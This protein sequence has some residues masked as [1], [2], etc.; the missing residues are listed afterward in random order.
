MTDV[1]IIIPSYNRPDALDK[2]L[3]SIF[4]KEKLENIEVVVYIDGNLE[5]FTNVIEKYK[6]NV[7]FIKNI[8]NYGLATALNVSAYKSN[9]E[10]LLI[11]NDDNVF[12]I[13][14]DIKLKKMIYDYDLTKLCV[15]INQIEPKPSIYRNIKIYDCGN[16]NNFNSNLF[17]EMNVEFS[18]DEFFDYG[19]GLFPFLI[20]KKNFMIVNG[21]DIMYNSPYIM[22]WDFFLKLE[23]NDIKM[24]LSKYFHLYHFGSLSTKNNDDKFLVNQMNIKEQNGIKFFKYK[25]GTN[26]SLGQNNTKINQYL[27][28]KYF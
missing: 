28:N 4:Y 14:F 22:D 19:G 21:F 5:L 23:L 25:W 6:N 9:G 26:P 24:K 17:N 1:S 12:P 15:T 20:S 16:I 18:D 27:K 2:C 3:G 13:G 8:K 10:F 7:N 11:I